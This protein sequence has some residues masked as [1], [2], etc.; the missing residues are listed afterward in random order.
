MFIAAVCPS[1][2]AAGPVHPKRGVAS[3]KYLW[4][5]PMRLTELR[6]TWVYDWSWV[7]PESTPGIEWVPM[8]WGSRTV[9]ATR[10]RALSA[11]RRS[12]RARVLLGFNEPDNP[13]QSNMTP[14]RAADLWP[15]LESTGLRLGSPAPAVADDG[16]LDRFMSLALARRL[17][18]DFIA[19]HFYQDFTDPRAVDELHQQ[20]LAIHARYR[21]PIWIT[22]IGEF[23]IRT[24]HEHMQS[25]PTY[26]LASSYMRNVL[27]MLDRLKFVERY[28]WF[29]DNCWS[30]RACRY[31]SLFDGYDRLTARGDTYRS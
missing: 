9:N 11:D 29:T 15:Q 3:A 25:P 20:L 31:G 26:R 27:A 30:D 4:T 7:A 22:E 17:R 12:G 23:D 10:I 2:A 16:W 8:V 1:I 19:L 14:V 6:V 13:S 28:A 21:K 18:V 5:T 24:W